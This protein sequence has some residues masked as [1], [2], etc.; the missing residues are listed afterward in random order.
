MSDKYNKLTILKEVRSE[1]KN[2]RWRKIVQCECE[3]GKVIERPKSLV[4]NGYIKSC[5]CIKTNKAK[6][7]GKRFGAW[8]V[9]KEIEN[10]RSGRQFLCKCDCGVERVVNYSNLLSKRS[11]SCGC[12][13]RKYN[14][15]YKKDIPNRDRL[16]NIY[17]GMKDRCYNPNNKSYKYYGQ[18]GISICKEWLDE[19]VGFEN[20]ANWSNKN[21]YNDNLSIDRINVNG[22]Y[23][24]SNCRWATNSM[25]SRNK[26]N[27]V[28]LTYNGKTQTVSEWA[29][30][31]GCAY[32]TIRYRMAH[33]WDI[34][35]ILSKPTR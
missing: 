14:I 15:K 16:L 20:F 30:E 17:I 10:N 25:Q 26:R 33:G 23:E 35:D 8:L 21:N 32:N 34:E 13:P 6:V 27:N 4:V 1:Y 3:C 12:T 2:G 5:G 9:I 28:Y 19:N 24:P 22:N 7:I 11:S 18:R 31:I 29:K